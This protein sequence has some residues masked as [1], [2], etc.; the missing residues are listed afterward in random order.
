MYL[1]LHLL[2]LIYLQMKRNL[3]LNLI[4]LLLFFTSIGNAQ[5]PKLSDKAKISVLTC[6][7]GDELYSIF[8]HTA[9]RVFDPTNQIDIVYN[10]G[11][12]DFDTSFFYL[13]FMYGS[14]EYYL[15]SSSYEDF[16][17]HYQITNRSVFEQELVVEQTV[18]QKMFNKLHKEINS[19]EKFYTYQFIEQNCTTKVADLLKEFIPKNSLSD[20]YSNIDELSYRGIINTFLKDRYFEKLGINLLFGLKTDKL[21]DQIFLPNDLMAAITIAETNNTDLSNETNTIYLKSEEGDGFNIFNNVFIV[22]ILF[23]AVIILKKQKLDLIFIKVL[24]SLGIFMLLF[25]LISQHKEVGYNINIL[26]FNPLLL[27]LAYA[28]KK[29]NESTFKKVT[30][31]LIASALVFIFKTINT[32]S[33]Y[34]VTP[35]LIPLVFIVY[36]LPF[37]K[38]K[39]NDDEMIK[40]IVEK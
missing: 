3:L 2:I 33:F 28:Y 25:S 14:L 5:A 40:N 20:S 15:S 36:R 9:I 26:L 1:K 34:I 16:I 7:G 11:T 22:L 6:G 18:K 4:L 29:D 10:Y 19:E 8:G 30:W 32:S 12:F 13:K 21:S 35:F 37:Y 38:T 17:Y 24:G 39:I 31:I 27:L 23:A